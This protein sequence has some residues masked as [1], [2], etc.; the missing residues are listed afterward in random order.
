MLT[1]TVQLFGTCHSSVSHHY[2]PQAHCH[3]C[4]SSPSLSL[5]VFVWVLMHAAHPL[6]SVLALILATYYPHYVRSDSNHHYCPSHTCCWLVQPV[7]LIADNHLSSPIHPQTLSSLTICCPQWFHNSMTSR[8]LSTLL[9]RLCQIPSTFFL[10]LSSGST[11]NILTQVLY[12]FKNH[13]V[14]IPIASIWALTSVFNPAVSVNAHY[15]SVSC[16]FKHE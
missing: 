5:L 12:S 1:N 8:P 9:S 15:P 13:Y 4:L 10:P 2:Q 3:I 6:V 16:S 7:V 14:P 11:R